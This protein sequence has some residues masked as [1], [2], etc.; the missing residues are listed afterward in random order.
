MRLY[1]VYF[2]LTGILLAI[3]GVVWRGWFWLMCWFGLSLLWLSLAHI[4]QNHHLF[5]KRPDGTIP[6]FALLLHLPFFG[7]LHVLWH[8]LRLLSREPAYHAVTDQLIVGRRLLVGELPSNCDNYIDLTAEYGEPAAVR[9]LSGY[10]CFPILDGSAPS[11]DALARF[12]AAL[13][14]GRTFVHCAQGHGRSGLFA[15]AMLLAHG[16]VP[17]IEEGLCLLQNARPRI[18]LN[19]AQRRCLDEFARQSTVTRRIPPS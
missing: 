10:V 9:G 12:I 19:A 11:T 13:R 3:A 4:R 16:V 2:G 7:Y 18:W 1:A 17:N 15:L 8:T 14:P 6:L 5:G